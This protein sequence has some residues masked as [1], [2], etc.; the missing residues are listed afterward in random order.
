VELARRFISLTAV[1]D[2]TFFAA[3]LAAAI[4]FTTRLKGLINKTSD[5][6]GRVSVTVKPLVKAVV[7]TL[8]LWTMRILIS[9]VNLALWL[10]LGLLWWKLFG[11]W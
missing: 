4:G 7:A 9:L 3:I 1:T 8:S 11:W 10:G 6:L 2:K 5:G